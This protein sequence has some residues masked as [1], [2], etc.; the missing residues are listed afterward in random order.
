[1]ELDCGTPQSKLRRNGIGNPTHCVEVVAV[2]QTGTVTFTVTD[3]NDAP[4]PSTIRSLYFL[5]LTKPFCANE[6]WQCRLSETLTITSVTQPLR[7]RGPFLYRT[8]KFYI[9][10]TQH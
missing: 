6:R 8:T 7:V 9:L 3:V 2:K 5:N 4:T 10:G 1:M